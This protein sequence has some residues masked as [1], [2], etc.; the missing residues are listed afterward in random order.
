MQSRSEVT[1]V[2]S[3]LLSATRYST[4][5]KQEMKQESHPLKRFHWDFLTKNTNKVHE[6][7]KRC[8]IFR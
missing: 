1:T 4:E 3:H 6:K 7:Q 2:S 8:V 5:R